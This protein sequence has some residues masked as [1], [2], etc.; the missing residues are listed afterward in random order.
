MNPKTGEWEL[1]QIDQYFLVNGI[2]CEQNQRILAHPC[3]C[4]NKTNIPWSK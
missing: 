1:V 4:W 3:F 2:S